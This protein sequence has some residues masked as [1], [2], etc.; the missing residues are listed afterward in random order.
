MTWKVLL[1]YPIAFCFSRDMQVVHM[2]VGMLMVETIF[3]P[4]WADSFMLPN[5]FRASRDV[6]VTLV[7]GSITMWSVRVFG[8]WLLGV[9][10][11]MQGYGVMLAMCI[12]WI[13]RCA[14]Y[15]PRFR[16]DKWLRKVGE[17]QPVKAR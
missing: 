2:A 13:A 5:V 17:N 6:K 8:A 1:A 4:F 12:D 3:M 11:G 15:T 7:T 14:V 10:L 16:G 9:K